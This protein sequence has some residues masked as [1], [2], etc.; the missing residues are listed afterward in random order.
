MQAAAFM[1]LDPARNLLKL[2]EPQYAHDLSDLALRIR[3]VPKLPPGDRPAAY[4]ALLSLLACSDAA[5]QLAAISSLQ[6]CV[7]GH[8][9]FARPTGA[10]PRRIKAAFSTAV[11]LISIHRSG[12]HVCAVAE[13][14]TFHDAL[15]ASASS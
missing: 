13:R 4:R 15:Y 12:Y 3:W 8:T 2:T 9:D 1:L 7:A 14:A 5:L 6:V 11:R 10:A